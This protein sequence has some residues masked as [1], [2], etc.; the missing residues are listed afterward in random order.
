MRSRV[1]VHRDTMA[2]GIDAPVLVLE[3]EFLFLFCQQ[4]RIDSGILDEFAGFHEALDTRLEQRLLD[5]LPRSFRAATQPLPI[6]QCNGQDGAVPMRP[7]ANVDAGAVFPDRCVRRI[8]YRPGQE[9]W[10]ERGPFVFLRP[11]TPPFVAVS[12]APVDGGGSGDGEAHGAS[13][14]KRKPHGRRRYVTSL[15]DGLGRRPTVR[16]VTG[17]RGRLFFL[18]LKRSRI[19]I[20][21]GDGGIDAG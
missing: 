2:H 13:N 7:R 1:P 18:I 6:E 17:P 16:F 11:E 21:A 8:G 5:P 14:E 9:V 3:F 12:G 19:G 4:S 20:L 10:P 15:S